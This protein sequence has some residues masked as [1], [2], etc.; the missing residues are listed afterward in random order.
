MHSQP[1]DSQSTV[2]A[3]PATETRK[4]KFEQVCWKLRSV[5]NDK[6]CKR[7]ICCTIIEKADWHTRIG[8]ND[9]RFKDYRVCATENIGMGSSESSEWNMCRKAC[10]GVGK[11]AFLAGR[12]LTWHQ[13]QGVVKLS[14]SACWVKLR[15]LTSCQQVQE[16]QESD[17][18]HEGH[19]GTLTWAYSYSVSSMLKQS[20]GSNNMITKII[21]S[22]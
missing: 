6:M 8:T 17:E 20:H 7:E 13:K 14:L 3:Q 22:Q 15:V 21:N 1:K 2:Y 16:L 11:C 4:W 19:V 5:G 12:S 10:A 9:K 18:K